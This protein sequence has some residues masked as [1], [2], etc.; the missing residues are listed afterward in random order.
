MKKILTFVIAAAGA[1]IFS[2]CNMCSDP[3]DISC[4]EASHISDK[5]LDPSSISYTAPKIVPTRDVF[6][7]TFRAG[8][9]RKVAVGSGNS[10]EE[11]TSDAIIKFKRENKCDYI[12]SVTREIVKRTHPTWRFFATTNYQVT[13]YG[14]PVYL[15]KLIR[16][17]L[18]AEKEQPK[19]EETQPQ[20]TKADIVTIIKEERQKSQVGL[21]K[22][23]DIN[24]QINAKGTTNDKAGMVFPAD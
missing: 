15:D 10:L 9:E 8:T 23:H 7:P 18:P 14:L 20:L 22:L 4:E 17:E 12:V 3:I 16:E 5:Q 6:R 2:G 11:A 24:V 19:A 21:L 13:I 1:A